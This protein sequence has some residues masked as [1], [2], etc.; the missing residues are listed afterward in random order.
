MAFLGNVS[1]LF[2]TYIEKLLK[3]WLATVC[4]NVTATLRLS[5][6][7]AEDGNRYI[8]Y[9]IADFRTIWYRGS[10]QLLNPRIK[11]S[12]RFSCALS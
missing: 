3:A 11:S 5:E 2:H 10:W 12:T 4:G 9:G 6:P 1:A 7:G 8:M